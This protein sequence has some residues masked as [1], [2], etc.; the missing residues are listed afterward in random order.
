MIFELKKN[1]KLLDLIDNQDKKFICAKV[2]GKIKSLDF[3]IDKD[4]DYDIEFL[5]LKS[6]KACRIYE[7]SLRYIAAMAVKSLD[8]SLDIRY[9]YYISRSIYGQFVS[10]KKGPIFN[11]IF[12]KKIKERMKEIIEKDIPFKRIKCSKDEALKLYRQDN[13]LDKIQVLKYRKENFAHIYEAK[14]NSFTYSDYLYEELVPSSG[15]IKLFDIKPYTPGFL[16]FCPKA[17]CGG[18]IPPYI[19][20]GRFASALS[21]NASFAMINNIDTTNNIN[22]YIHKNTEV[23]L[24]CI[25]EARVNRQLV[26]VTDEIVSSTKPIKLICIAGPSSSGKT[27]F[28][29]RLM[30]ELMSVGKRTIRISID[31]F[32]IPKGEMK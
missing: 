10:K 21:E 14:Y 17:E 18:E 6:A 1:Q 25:S 11:Y 5:T 28:A 7:A 22:K 8:E 3:I 23:G 27:S 24:I 29:N 32:Y 15:Y 20:E 19:V 4:G 13:K 2:D 12:I 16:L 31:D 9:S 26:N 30:Y